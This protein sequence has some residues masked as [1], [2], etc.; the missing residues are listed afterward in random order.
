M[1]VYHRKS[2]EYEKNQKFIDAIQQL[3]INLFEIF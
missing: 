1:C 2:E 3:S